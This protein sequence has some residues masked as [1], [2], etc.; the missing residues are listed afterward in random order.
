MKISVIGAGVIGGNF[1]RK[2]GEA[3]H[4]VQ[5]A[6]ARRSEAV[7]P[8]V[9]ET[10]ARAV[11]LEDAVKD[12]D[13]VVLA[14]PFGVAGQLADLFASV[15]AETVVIDTSNHY[16]HLSGRI[17]TV[18]D[19]AIESVYTSELLGRPVVK[20]W[21]AA[22]AGTQRTKVAPAGTPGVS[23]RWAPPTAPS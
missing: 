18:E 10:G 19:G 14:I 9:L 2:L 13:A 16:P 3:G 4:D 23:N 22:L 5:V 1:A 8:D 21:Y 15:P 11:A 20:A 7:A 17:E 12:R 6:D